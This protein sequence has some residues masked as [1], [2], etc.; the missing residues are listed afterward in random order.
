M[1]INEESKERSKCKFQTAVHLTDVPPDRR[2][3][4]CQWVF[5]VRHNG[6]CYACSGACEYRQMPGVGLTENFSPVI[7]DVTFCLLL[8]VKIIRV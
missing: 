5:K 2:M 3:I 1:A 7:S 4:R 6:V 8:V